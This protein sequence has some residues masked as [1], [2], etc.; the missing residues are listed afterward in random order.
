MAPMGRFHAMH[1]AD[2]L[3][4][5][6]LVTAAFA[7]LQDSAPRAGL[8][9]L[10]ARADGITP[11]AWEHP[12]LAQVWGPRGAVYLIPADAIAAF[13]VGR[14]DGYRPRAVIRWDARTTAVLTTDLPDVSPAA[15]RVDLARRFVAWF[16]DAMRSRFAHWAALDDDVAADA[17]RHVAPVQLPDGSVEGVRLLPLMDP[18]L[19]GR[20]KPY[21]SDTYFHNTIVVDGRIV[22]SFARKQRHVRVRTRSR[23][24]DRIEAEARSL[25]GPLGGDVRFEVEVV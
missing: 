9:S 1:L 3:P 7:G 12:S 16:G 14:G 13:T 25:A 2:R 21:G 18:Y 17:L 23:A 8:L 11:D 15:A 19:Y 20:P 24:L 4:A 10:H 5:G 22:G 6:E